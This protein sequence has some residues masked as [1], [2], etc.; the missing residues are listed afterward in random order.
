MDP[1]LSKLWPR[2]GR[3]EL[4]RASDRDVGGVFSEPFLVGI[5][6]VYGGKT[7]EYHWDDEIWYNMIYP[8]VI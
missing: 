4:F 7:M 5:Q 3:D 2:P 1:I 8:L 6:W